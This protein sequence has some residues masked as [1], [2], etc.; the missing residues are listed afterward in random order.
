MPLIKKIFFVG[1]KLLKK[2][3][4]FSFTKAY[5]RNNK[6]LTIE[7]SGGTQKMIKKIKKITKSPNGVLIKFPKKDKI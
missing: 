3:G 2:S 4:N 7:G 5:F 1:K 6:I